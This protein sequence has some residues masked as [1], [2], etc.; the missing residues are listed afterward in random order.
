MSIE[1]AT[2]PRIPA[3]TPN[4]II[5][6]GVG[7]ILAQD[8][9]AFV[10][11]ATNNRL[12]IGNVAP[13]YPLDVTGIIHTTL[14]VRSEPA[15]TSIRLN[16]ATQAF[17]RTTSRLYDTSA[18][19]DF[20]P[21]LTQMDAMFLASS[22]ASFV[23]I[24]NAIQ[25]A[26]R[27]NDYTQFFNGT[28]NELYIGNA[29][30]FL[31][32]AVYMGS[33]TGVAGTYVWEYSTGAGTWAALTY[34][35]GTAGVAT[36]SHTAGTLA[37]ISWVDPVGTAWASVTINGVAGFYIRA[38]TTVAPST[39]P[40]VYAMS[41]SLAGGYNLR[42]F[43]GTL[44]KVRITH[45]GSLLTAGYIYPGTQIAGNAV[46][47]AFAL[48]AE[49]GGLF[50][51]AMFRVATQLGVGVAPVSTTEILAQALA[52]THTPLQ[53]LGFSTSQT[54]DLM[55]IWTSASQGW[56]FD[57]LGRPSHIQTTKPTIANGAAAGTS[58]GTPVVTTGS[59]DVVGEITIITGNPTASGILCTVT[60]STAFAT[61]PKYVNLVRFGTAAGAIASGSLPF[62]SAITTTTFQ[63][64]I[65][66][67]GGLV[68]S[69]TYTFKYLVIA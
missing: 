35:E 23:D 26:P 22:G 2:P 27:S 46:Q 38:R 29:A 44:E 36:F 49:T 67:G 62:V 58:P 39:P 40:Q 65:P 21:A 54:A 56:T 32:L 4:G 48:G 51:T 64:S 8:P 69:T 37:W 14:Y 25:D 9:T 6:A 57:K 68:S 33:P 31:E 17:Y 41:N 7:G 63:I 18:I 30:K 59:T 19:L 50:T 61:A 10:W 42:A 3:F 28:Q 34:T 52:I 1:Y 45:Y 20:H 5:Y 43:I 24:T 15:S 53:V 12:G 66:T 13:A 60:F 16:F 11:D 47:G 55:R